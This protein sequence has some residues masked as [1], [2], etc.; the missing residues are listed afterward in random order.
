MDRRRQR[1][2]RKNFERPKASRIRVDASSGLFVSNDIFTPSD[3]QLRQQL[4][5]AV[6]RPGVVGESRR[7]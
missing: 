7:S 2:R 4:G 6:I 5:D 3:F 1:R